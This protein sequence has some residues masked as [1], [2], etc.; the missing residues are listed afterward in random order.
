MR[1]V[2]SIK[3]KVSIRNGSCFTARVVTPAGVQPHRAPSSCLPSAYAR[4]VLLASALYLCSACVPENPEVQSTGATADGSSDLAMHFA[5]LHDAYAREFAR[6]LSEASGSPVQVTDLD[7]VCLSATDRRILALCKDIDTLAPFENVFEVYRAYGVTI[8][9]TSDWWAEK[10]EYLVAAVV[11]VDNALRAAAGPIDAPAGEI[12]DY[13]YDEQGPIRFEYRGYGSS[14]TI[15]QSHIRVGNWMATTD[16]PLNQVHL[17][18]HE[19]GHAF[20]RSIY[21]RI[22]PVDRAAGLHPTAYAEVDGMLDTEGPRM[23]I[24]GDHMATI[25]D[26]LGIDSTDTGE[27]WLGPE[28][29]VLHNQELTWVIGGGEISVRPLTDARGRALRPALPLQQHL[30]SIHHEL[31]KGRQ[32]H[33]RR[34]CRHVPQLVLRQLCRQRPRACSVAMDAGARTAVVGPNRFAFAPRAT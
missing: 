8:D 13:V 34:V 19:L 33:V 7:A 3:T 24:T 23:P 1:A 25:L 26:M 15:S 16:L 14:V 11:R 2:F 27:H 6:L 32:S 17:F 10:R 28:K 30:S 22:P 29:F 18:T 31:E 21:G 20:A 4:G 12:F 9:D 5:H